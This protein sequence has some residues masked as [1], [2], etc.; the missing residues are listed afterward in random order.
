MATGWEV[1][2]ETPL[3]A[4][5]SGGGPSGWEIASETPLAAPAPQDDSFLSRVGHTLLG[6]AQ[7]G[8]SMAANIPH[9]AARAVVDLYR[10]LTGGNTDA[11]MPAA[12]DAIHVPVGKAGQ[13]LLSTVQSFGNPNA[14]DEGQLK[15]GAIADRFGAPSEVVQDVVRHAGAVGQDVMDI[16]PVAA[17][18]KLLPKG[19]PATPASEAGLRSGAEHPI[20]RA[21]AGNSGRD[22][23]TLQNAKVANT[24]AASEAGHDLHAPLTNESLAAAR[25]A[26]NSVYKRVANNLPVGPL[27]AQAQAEILRAGQPEGGR[28]T[29]G[30][31]QAQPAITALQDQ[32]TSAHATPTGQQIVNELR[33]LRQEG[34][35]NIGSDDVSNQELGHA[36][37]G[38]ARAIEGHISRNLIPGGDT[39]IEQFQAARTA[40]AKNH[41][42]EAAL[43]GG[44]VDLAALARMNRADPELMTGGLK[45]LADFADAHPPVSGLPQQIYNP[46]SFTSDVLGRNSEHPA[47]ILNPET[48]VGATGL[49]AGARKVLRG[50]GGE[51]SAIERA[52][53]MFGPRPPD[54]FGPLPRPT[55]PGPGS[56]AVDMTP[57]PSPGLSLAPEGAVQA[58]QT[59]PGGL[60]LAD[61]L[62]TGVER[63]TAP[64]LSLADELG[65]GGRP[66]EGI[67]YRPD[68]AF[69]SRGAEIAPEDAWFKGGA[70]DLG[71][72]ASVMSQGVPEG[73]LMRSGGSKPNMR[74]GD[75]IDMDEPLSKAAHGEFPL[76]NNASGESAASLE[77]I[78]RGTRNIVEI[79]PDGNAR[80]VLRD[81]TQ[82]DRK[83]PKGH[84]LVD[85]DTGTIIDRGGLAQR[86]AENLKAR[87]GASQRIGDLLAGH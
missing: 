1:A 40:L 25:A 82:V 63:P 80:P 75:V 46:P 62:S 23:L 28:I 55:F 6:E 81:V 51:D 73:T 42:V 87:W 50:F 39:S 83:A 54:A 22:A 12:V 79:D 64:G 44:N 45:V 16:A 15:Q 30:S 37:L 59:A 77:A 68:P 10:R 84:I 85:A 57:E 5:P 78:N 8:G 11:P 20:A 29:V 21:I 38:M 35:K 2:S 41:A 32:L 3:G 61:V 33:G 66:G 71:D 60:S 19:V 47:S 58:P 72:L 34:F 48:W 53:R 49:K 14:V 36:Q 4:A 86:L 31:P 26:P 70:P 27:D 52:N 9:N 24:I 18:G 43:R 74:L 56:G 76:E 13:D 17:A 69:L 65:A 67:P 7:L